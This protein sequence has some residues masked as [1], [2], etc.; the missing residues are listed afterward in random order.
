MVISDV[1]LRLGPPIWSTSLTSG[2]DSPNIIQCISIVGT[3]P[4]FN[5][6]DLVHLNDLLFDEWVNNVIKEALK[7][8]I[9]VVQM[10]AAPKNRVEFH[11]GSNGTIRSSL[12]T[13][14][15]VSQSRATSLTLCT[16]I[17]GR[18]IE[19]H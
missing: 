2:R 6:F 19:M 14:Y 15:E 8:S 16:P 3:V 12:A 11:Q 18:E 10:A 13:S 9:F 17:R 5:P 4:T 1:V 7:L